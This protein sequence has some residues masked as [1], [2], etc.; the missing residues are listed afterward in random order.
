MTDSLNHV[1]ARV[2]RNHPYGHALHGPESSS[3]LTPGTCG[4]LTENGA[5]TPLLDL[6]N[7]AAVQARG[8]TPFNSIKRAP[9]SSYLWGPKKSDSVTRVSVALTAAA[10]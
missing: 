1:Y 8:F 5:W 2:L 9:P 7:A 6:S 4:Y 3:V 10:A